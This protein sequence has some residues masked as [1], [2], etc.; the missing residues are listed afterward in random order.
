MSGDLHS[1]CA[2][3]LYQTPNFGTIRANFLGQLRPA[4][5]NCRVVHQYANNATQA[6]V[7][8]ER[9][10][11]F[12]AVF[13]RIQLSGSNAGIIGEIQEKAQQPG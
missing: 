9:R 11:L 4:D 5:Y 1:E 3:L 13:S 2:Q 10:T 12:T 7:G 6:G 8:L